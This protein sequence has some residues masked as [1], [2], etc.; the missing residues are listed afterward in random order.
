M[1]DIARLTVRLEDVEPAVVRQI[2]VPLGIR[3]SDLHL[4]LQIVMG[5]RII[6]STSFALAAVWRGASRTRVGRTSPPCRPRRR[7]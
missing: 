5:G 2:E 6:T 3:L 7:H 1:T 4:V